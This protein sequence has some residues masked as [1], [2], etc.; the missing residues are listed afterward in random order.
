MEMS[1]GTDP[2]LSPVQPAGGGSSSGFEES[3][4]GNNS[5]S[6]MNDN[7]NESERSEMIDPSAGDGGSLLVVTSD[8]SEV[9]SHPE[10]DNNLPEANVNSGAVGGELSEVR[11][12]ATSGVITEST[13]SETVQDSEMAAAGPSPS[14]DAPKVE[15]LTLDLG[16]H[17]LQIKAARQ[18]NCPFRQKLGHGGKQLLNLLPLSEA[19]DSASKV[20]VDPG[21]MLS[22]SGGL[23]KFL[24][25]RDESFLSSLPQEERELAQK[26]TAEF[27]ESVPPAMRQGLIN[28]MG[29]TNEFAGL[30]GK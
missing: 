13:T 15:E 2:Q 21:S 3:S 24:C 26:V 8:S 25:R 9:L 28:L 5:V 6:S 17:P 30:S 23:L 18:L 14:S 16:I 7:Q 19:V 12:D 20:R 1:S 4:T 27:F 29:L 10:A 11:H 22:A